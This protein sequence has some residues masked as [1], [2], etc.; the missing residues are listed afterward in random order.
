LEEV[1]LTLRHLGGLRG[2]VHSFAGSQQQAERLW[3]MGFCLGIGGTVTY[4]RA[5]RLQ[6][7]VANMPS[8]FL[9]LESDAPDQ[10]DAAHRGQRNEPARV[11]VIAQCIATLRAEPVAAVAAATSANARRLFRLDQRTP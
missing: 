8:E 11:A 9:L 5:Q 1:I 2:V 7:I 6:R 4:P 3:Q 10:P